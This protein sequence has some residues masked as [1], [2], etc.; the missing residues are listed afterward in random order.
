MK[1]CV[2]KIYVDME[3]TIDTIAKIEKVWELGETLYELM[4]E[5]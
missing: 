2:I 5:E 4:R 3:E 1:I